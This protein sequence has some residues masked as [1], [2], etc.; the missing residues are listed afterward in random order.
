[1]PFFFFLNLRKLSCPEA[2]DAVFCISGVEGG[3]D[4]LVMEKRHGQNQ[5]CTLKPEGILV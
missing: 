5:G 1:M 4:G 2:A 3:E